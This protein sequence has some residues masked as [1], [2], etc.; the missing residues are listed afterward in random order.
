MGDFSSLLDLSS[1]ELR[2][3]VEMAIDEDLGQG[4]LTTSLTVPV[5]LRACGTFRSKQSLVVAGL[6]VAAM[7][8]QVLKP[9]WSGSLRSRT[10]RRLPLELFWRPRAAPPPLCSRANA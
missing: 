8:F 6:P 5:G 3:L 2:T 10:A 7:V 9:Q 4:D 1:G